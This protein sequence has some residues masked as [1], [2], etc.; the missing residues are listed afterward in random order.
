MPSTTPPVHDARIEE[1]TT[2]TVDPGQRYYLR[3]SCYLQ[4]VR[5][6]ALTN[7]ASGRSRPWRAPPLP[8]HAARVDRLTGHNYG[9]Q[10]FAREEY[11]PFIGGP[12]LVPRSSLRW[13]AS[14]ITSWLPGCWPSWPASGVASAA[15]LQ[16]GE[17]R[18]EY[19]VWRLPGRL[20]HVSTS[21]TATA[22][23]RSRTAPTLV[24]SADSFSE[25]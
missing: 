11:Q 12:H 23:R 7:G 1:R 6:A 24:C 25:Q 4:P 21:W 19:P 18:R 16:D 9:L 14:S 15:R 10:R 5:T 13:R 2:E 20:R 22:I 3:R 17:R 8:P